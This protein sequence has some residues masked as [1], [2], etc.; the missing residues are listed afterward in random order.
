MLVSRFP[1]GS[2]HIT[3]RSLACS[4]CYSGG[5]ALVGR[6]I[7]W[8]A[9]RPD[10]CTFRPT[11][12]SFGRLRSG[13]PRRSITPAGASLNSPGSHRRITPAGR[14]TSTVDARVRGKHM[15]SLSFL[16]RPSGYPEYRHKSSSPQLEM[17]GARGGNYC[18]N[19]CRCALHV[20]QNLRPLRLRSVLPCCCASS[21]VGFHRLHPILS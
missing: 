17:S 12:T 11:L 14:P 19:S 10:L 20:P 16:S 18:W 5:R 13:L 6:L 3:H 2:D 7:A 1:W 15:L 4:A 8:N 21:N 9:L